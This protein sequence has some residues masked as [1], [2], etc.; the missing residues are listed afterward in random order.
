VVYKINLTAKEGRNS[1]D[2]LPKRQEWAAPSRRLECIRNWL[3]S[4][5]VDRV[6][7]GHLAHGT[8]SLT[9]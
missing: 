9:D 7:Q 6:P 5:D 1:L 2:T 8:H 3:P 4:T